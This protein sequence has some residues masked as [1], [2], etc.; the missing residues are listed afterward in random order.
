MGNDIVLRLPLC[1]NNLLCARLTAGAVAS[2][3]DIDVEAAED[4]KVCVNEACLIMV[5]SGFSTA[6]I[7]FGMGEALSIEISGEG[8]CPSPMS[9]AGDNTE[10]SMLLI[11][12]LVDEV[13]YTG[14]DSVIS[15]VN[16]IK[17]I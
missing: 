4:I 11:K 12:S 1:T 13:H 14:E 15:K 2:L 17:R 9:V 7:T 5:G 6:Q 16:L 3:M 10:I 8:S